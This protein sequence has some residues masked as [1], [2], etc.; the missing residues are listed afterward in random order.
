MDEIKTGA[1]YI[2]VSDE[3]QDECSLDSQKKKICEFAA[4]EGYINTP[5]K[6]ITKNNQK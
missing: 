1:A 4:K 2:R 3:R 6:E 5:K